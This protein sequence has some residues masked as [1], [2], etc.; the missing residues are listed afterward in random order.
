MPHQGHADGTLEI[1]A[2]DIVEEEPAGRGSFAPVVLDSAPRLPLF[3]TEDRYPTV[4]IRIR[5]DRRRTLRAVVAS[6]MG[7]CLTLLFVAA[8]RSHGAASPAGSSAKASAAIAMPHADVAATSVDSTP[9][10]SVASTAS[11]A[12]TGT[13]MTEQ[14]AGP[15]ALDGVRRSARTAVVPCGQ[16]ELRLG[17][18]A[19]QQVV[20]PCGGSLTIGRK[21]KITV[22]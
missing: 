5:Q 16:H 13:I 11:P 8:V 3:A 22:E 19:V 9:W 17:R 4:S 6:S 21:G 20:V 2:A 14:A 18:G 10:T 12:R 15:W 1:D 7:L